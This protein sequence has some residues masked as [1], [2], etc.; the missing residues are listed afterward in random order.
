MGLSNP[1][2]GLAKSV[3]QRP[4]IIKY[5]SRCNC[6]ASCNVIHSKCVLLDGILKVYFYVKVK[7]F[8]NIISLENAL[9]QNHVQRHNFFIYCIINQGRLGRPGAKIINV[10]RAWIG[11]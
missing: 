11:A 4:S 5:G 10:F 8:V 1:F 9:T 3:Y 7:I 2:S 6:K